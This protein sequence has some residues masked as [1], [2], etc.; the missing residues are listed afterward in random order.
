MHEEI[1]F[2]GMTAVAEALSRWPALAAF[3]LAGGTALAL[4]LGH[5][6]SRDLDLFTRQPMAV[7]PPLPGMDEALGSYHRVEWELN[8]RE[9]I[10]WRLDGVSVTLLA[11][12][13]AHRFPL[14]AWRGL[15]VADARDVAVQK[16]YTLGRRA[17][18]RDYLDLHAA[19]TGGVLSLDDVLQWGPA[20]YGDAFSPRLF[21]QQLTYTRDVMD[22]DSA[23]ALLATP[24]PFATIARELA[25]QVQ[26]WGR[27]HWNPPGAPR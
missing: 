1:L 6:Q 22:R 24:R 15:S 18:A 16:A 13:F 11:Y 19:L 26:A 20:T 9:Q 25:V 5:R 21:L 27:A 3:Y 7:L 17:Q 4:H 14:H 12:P 2:D 8:T 10:S 23:L